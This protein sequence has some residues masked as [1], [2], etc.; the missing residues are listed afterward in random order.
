M[1]QTDSSNNKNFV[2]QMSEEEKITFLQ[3]LVTLA[4]ADN[5]FD[6]E[7]KSF[8]KESAIVFGLTQ[9]HVDQ[10]LTPLSNEEL[11]Q[12]ASKLSSRQAALQLIKE[13]CL[14]A[15]SDG[16]LSEEEILFIGRIG[17]AMNIELEKIEE[18]SQW[19]IERIIW[20]ER[21]KII[22]EQI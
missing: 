11:I 21:G 3:I 15:N 6:N 8:I 1:S 2:K 19:V 14:L 4:K 5:N 20:L 22:F 10:I 9:D 7:E 16:D 18:I 12:K 13:A 17:Q